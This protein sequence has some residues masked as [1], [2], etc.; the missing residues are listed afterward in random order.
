[1]E[2]RDALI[3]A[4]VVDAKVEHDTHNVSGFG[5][6]IRQIAGRRRIK[7]TIELEHRNKEE[8]DWLWQSLQENGNRISLIP[9]GSPIMHPTEVLERMTAATKEKSDKP[10]YMDA[11]W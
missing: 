11:Y 7:L 4:H 10:H 6:E 2:L 9:A 1:M 8:L 3:P 5:G